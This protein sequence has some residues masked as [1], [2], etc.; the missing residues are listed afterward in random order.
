[1]A[2]LNVC[3][4]LWVVSTDCLAG[5]CAERTTALLTSPWPARLPFVSVYSREDA[6]VDW[7]ACL[8]PA[9][10]QVEVRSTHNGMGTDPVVHYVVAGT[11]AKL[12]PVSRPPA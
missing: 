3:A 2:R 1:M 11:L 9:A 6:V 4:W 10:E 5:E 12:R 7:R 8:D